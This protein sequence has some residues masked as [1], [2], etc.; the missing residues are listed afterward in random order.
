MAQRA[1]RQWARDPGLGSRL[2]GVRYAL[3]RRDAAEL[4][5]H[6]W[7]AD[8]AAVL[9]EIEWCVEFSQA[10][11]GRGQMLLLPAPERVR[12]AA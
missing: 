4:L 12:E 2:S 8:M 11:Q 10:G 9:G 6:L 3:R 1:C 7:S 5:T